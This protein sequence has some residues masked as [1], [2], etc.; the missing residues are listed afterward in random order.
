MTI[1]IVFSFLITIAIGYFLLFFIFSSLNK[2]VIFKLLTFYLIVYFLFTFNIIVYSD[3]VS[4][5][6]IN[7]KDSLQSS[8]IWFIEINKTLK[9]YYLVSFFEEFLKLI[10]AF[11]L[12][13]LIRKRTFEYYKTST[14]HKTNIIFLSLLISA[15]SFSTIEN[16]IYL[17]STIFWKES[18]FEIIAYALWR[19]FYSFPMHLSTIS[20]FILISPLI[21][22]FI[23]DK[24]YLF[25]LLLSIFTYFISSSLHTFY[26][27][28]L[29]ENNS[30]KLSLFICYFIFSLT[31]I[32]LIVLNDKIK[33]DFIRVE[34]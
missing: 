19:I 22:K 21:F 4:N 34:N 3:V 1:P 26:N 6:Y 27:I 5:Y 2:K 18:Y 9:Y 29:I 24:K 11:F 15:I 20:L 12:F 28:S 32:K 8:F 25:T 10:F 7:L 30:F 31:S 17:V 14:L 16:I 33:K 13:F 23:K